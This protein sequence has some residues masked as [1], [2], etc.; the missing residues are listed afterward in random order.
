MASSGER[1]L[2]VISREGSS[3]RGERNQTTM[4][5]GQDALHHPFQLTSH[6]L[7]G[8]NYLEW[9]QSVKLVTD[10]RGKLGHLTG[11]VK[12]P[13][14]SD[15][16][17]SVWRSENS[18]NSAWLI[19]SMVPTIGLNREF[20]E[21]RSRVLENKPLPTHREAFSEVRREETR[22][23]VMLKSNSDMKPAPENSA[24]VST[25][26]STGIH[27]TLAEK[28]MESHRLRKKRI[29]LTTRLS[30]Q[31]QRS[32]GSRTLQKCLLSRRN[33]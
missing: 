20:D 22:R 31:P 1:Q 3:S 24:G 11:E 28:F 8:R 13:E 21:V 30:K 7:D 2:T 33:S 32:K 6:K 9:A 5:L 23:K 4:N 26:R 15:P 17:M 14:A 25:V 29:L 12:K 18:L 19:N 27:G 10:R 16:W